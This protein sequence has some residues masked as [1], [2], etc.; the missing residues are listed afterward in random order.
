MVFAAAFILS[1]W[2]YHEFALSPHLSTI[3]YSEFFFAIHSESETCVRDHLTAILA[4]ILASINNMYIV[5][6][7]SASG[8]T[9]ISVG[10][11]S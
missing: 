3:Y 8:W 9:F 6:T 1:I 2:R 5:Y 7:T 11:Y 4:C 10:N